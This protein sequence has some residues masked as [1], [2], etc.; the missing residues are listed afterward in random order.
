MGASHARS[1]GNTGCGSFSGGTEDSASSRS[2]I[3]HDPFEGRYKM[4][5]SCP[6]RSPDLPWLRLYDDIVEEGTI[7]YN[8]KNHCL[9]SK[10]VAT[11]RDRFE[12]AVPAIMDKNHVMSP[13]VRRSAPPCEYLPLSSFVETRDAITN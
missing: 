6:G 1:P 7:C 13:Q 10:P 2:M 3:L 5:L 9:D 12:E 11:N 4:H 8:T